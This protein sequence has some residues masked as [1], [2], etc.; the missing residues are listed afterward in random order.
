MGEDYQ[1]CPSTIGP[2]GPSQLGACINIDI[3]DDP[4][5]ENP[6]DF[7]AVL[8][9]PSDPLI[10]VDPNQNEATVNI[11]D[12]DGKIHSYIVVVTRTMS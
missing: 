2:F 1:Q 9:P 6:E 7:T 5:P 8:Q 10:S 11:A 12:N 4:I 3:N